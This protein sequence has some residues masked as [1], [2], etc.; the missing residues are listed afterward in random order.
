M[1]GDV[2]RVLGDRPRGQ[3]L[4]GVGFFDK[5]SAHGEQIITQVPKFQRNLLPDFLC[6]IG[7]RGH[8]TVAIRLRDRVINRGK[9]PLINSHDGRAGDGADDDAILEL[10][11]C[12]IR[13]L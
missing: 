11:G 5:C 7:T 1:C 12:A 9:F 6:R 4:D 13:C 8:N 2:I 3:R 10:R